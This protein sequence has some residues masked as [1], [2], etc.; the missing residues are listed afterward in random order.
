[1]CVCER[2]VPVLDPLF[3]LETMAL[4]T[5]VTAPGTCWDLSVALAAVPAEHAEVHSPSLP[6]PGLCLAKTLPSWCAWMLLRHHHSFQRQTFSVLRITPSLFASVCVRA[7]ACVHVRCKY[8]SM[9]YPLFNVN[10]S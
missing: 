9:A 6:V 7:H 3:G 5:F 10:A 8:E 1:M 4:A 2:D